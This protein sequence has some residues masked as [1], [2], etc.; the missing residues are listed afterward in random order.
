M[1]KIPSKGDKIPK[2]CKRWRKVWELARGGRDELSPLAKRGVLLRN[3]IIT[4]SGCSLIVR[5]AAWLLPPCLLGGHD[6]IMDLCEGWALTDGTYQSAGQWGWGAR[7]EMATLDPGCMQLKSLC[8]VQTAPPHL[9]HVRRCS[10]EAK[11]VTVFP[12]LFSL[13]TIHRSHVAWQDKE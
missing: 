8:G 3:F 7:S 1:K 10:F 13:K 4:C 12:F 9:R 11:F 5:R 6:R 2:P